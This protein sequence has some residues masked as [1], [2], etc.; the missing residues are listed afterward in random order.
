MERSSKKYNEKDT[1]MVTHDS[2]ILEGLGK[3]SGLVEAS[4]EDI[5]N[6]AIKNDEQVKNIQTLATSIQILQT[7]DEGRHASYCKEFVDINTK[8]ARD[9]DCLNTLKDK[10]KVQAG[11]DRYIHKKREWWQYMLGVLVALSSI[12]FGINQISTLKTSF[13]TS[14]SA[15]GTTVPAPSDCTRVIIDTVKIKGK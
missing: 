13:K 9:Y 1:T 3:L 10:D 11:V 8:L 7:T 15:Y 6:L 14:I 12:L 2:K 5:K 4:R